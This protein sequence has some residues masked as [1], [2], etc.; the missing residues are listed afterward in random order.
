MSK[1]IIGLTGEMGAGKDTFCKHIEKASQEPVFCFK[2]SNPLSEVL[3]VFFNE[4]SRE[5]QY[6]Q[7][8]NEKEGLK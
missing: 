6:G 1:I 8:L 7:D 2:F 3:K 5:D 4:V